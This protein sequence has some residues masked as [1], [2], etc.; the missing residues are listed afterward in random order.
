MQWGHSPELVL[1]AWRLSLTARPTDIFVK[2]GPVLIPLQLD[3]VCCDRA[4]MVQCSSLVHTAGTA[5]GAS[6]AADDA[7][8]S[9]SAKV[10]TWTSRQSAHCE[11]EK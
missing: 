7:G 3:G 8:A 11:L 5:G 10:V 9:S 2:Y 1:L 6:A 4:T